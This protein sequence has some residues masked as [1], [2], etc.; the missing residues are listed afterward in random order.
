MLDPFYPRR[1]NS[2]G[3]S[4][5]TIDKFYQIS[6]DVQTLRQVFQR[7][8]ASANA[9]ANCFCHSV[10]FFNAPS[11]LRRWCGTCASGAKC[12]WLTGDLSVFR[13]ISVAGLCFSFYPQPHKSRRR[14]RLQADDWDPS[15]DMTSIRGL[16]VMGSFWVHDVWGKG[17]QGF[18]GCVGTLAEFKVIDVR[19]SSSLS[20]SLPCHV[21]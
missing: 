16:F 1:L 8:N 14:V 4:S 13:G 10:R 5:R 9:L 6:I 2:W 21:S 20:T 19:V 3:I 15:V 18:C 12:D 11:T 17:I 7:S